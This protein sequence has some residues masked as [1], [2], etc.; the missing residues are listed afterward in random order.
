[1][2]IILIYFVLLCNMLIKAIYK[3]KSHK[4]K[5]VKINSHKIKYGKLQDK[6]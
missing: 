2:I 1:M 5:I 6:Y 4:K 3:R